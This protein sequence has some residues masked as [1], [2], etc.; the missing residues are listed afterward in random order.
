MESLGFTLNLA[1]P[2]MGKEAG[3]QRDR[4]Y[5]DRAKCRPGEGKVI[6]RLKKEE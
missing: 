2:E 5:D 6:V 4:L 3:R 1:K